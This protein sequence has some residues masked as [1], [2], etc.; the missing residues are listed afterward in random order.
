MLSVCQ[1]G[2]KVSFTLKNMQTDGVKRENRDL[3][4]VVQQGRGW[5]ASLGYTQHGP[6]AWHSIPFTRAPADYPQQKLWYAD[7]LIWLG[8]GIKTMQCPNAG[9]YQGADKTR[10]IEEQPAA[11]TE[12]ANGRHP[13][14]GKHNK[15]GG[16]C[17][18][19]KIAAYAPF[20]WF[21]AEWCPEEQ[22]EPSATRGLGQARYPSNTVAC[23]NSHSSSFRRRTQ[24]NPLACSALMV[25]LPI[26]FAFAKLI[27]KLVN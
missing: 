21:C 4:Q 24:T 1:S 19:L 16:G 17:F 26:P 3:L 12:L 7:S 11:G 2:L 23:R 20:Y 8:A 5:G 15:A 10:G 27:E 6:L 25:F 18:V 22:W 14:Q 13:P 9:L